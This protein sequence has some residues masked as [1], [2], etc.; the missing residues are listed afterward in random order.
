M[1]KLFLTT[2]LF[3]HSNIHSN[4]YYSRPSYPF[5]YISLLLLLSL[6]YCKDLIDSLGHGKNVLFRMSNR[7]STIYIMANRFTFCPTL[8]NFIISKSFT[9]QSCLI[10]QFIFSYHFYVSSIDV[11]I[12][13][14]TF[15]IDGMYTYVQT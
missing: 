5:F 3:L 6:Q 7:P 12:R 1:N 11:H 8:P 13:T 10:L 9:L 14:S 2:C 4:S 15:H